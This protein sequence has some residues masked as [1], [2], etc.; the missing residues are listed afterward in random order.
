[1]DMVQR[2]RRNSIFVLLPLAIAGAYFDYKRV[3]VSIILGGAIGLVNLKAI[4]WGVHA[5]VRPEDTT[6]AKGKLVFFSM[7][8]LLGIFIILAVLLKLKL[9]NILAIL[10]GLTVVFA[11]IILEGFKESRML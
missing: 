11:F 6:G 2:I 3:P 1:M 9:I 8:R 4:Q 7:L 10:A 5:M